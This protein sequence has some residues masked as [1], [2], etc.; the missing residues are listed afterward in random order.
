MKGLSDTL[1]T[2]MTHHCTSSSFP[3]CTQHSKSHRASAANGIPS[4]LEM[5]SLKTAPCTLLFKQLL[6]RLSPALQA[7]TSPTL[8]HLRRTESSTSVKAFH[9]AGLGEKLLFHTHI[10]PPWGDGICCR[11]SHRKPVRRHSRPC[12]SDC[13]VQAQTATRCTKPGAAAL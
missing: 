4:L 2:L 5:P 7:P 10:N 11:R 12:C 13:H 6:P 3:D 8:R 1:P 9:D